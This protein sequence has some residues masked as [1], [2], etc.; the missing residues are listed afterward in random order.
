MP[1]FINALMLGEVK[2]LLAASQSLILID[3][4]RLNSADNLKLRKDLRATGAMLK[5]AKVSILK[6][7]LP[8]AAA[9][10]CEGRSALGVV[11]ATDLIAAAK[12]L[13]DLAKEEKLTVRGAMMDGQAIDAAQVKRL[14]GLPAKQQLLGMLVNLLAA[15][16]TGLAR[17]IAE[18][19]KKQ[20]GAA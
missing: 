6:R 7:A 12:V 4:S 5:V 8:A 15:P 18:I 16:L 13:A 14:A 3:P 19:E 11:I 17:V 2:R 1:S 9:S 10:M 20:K